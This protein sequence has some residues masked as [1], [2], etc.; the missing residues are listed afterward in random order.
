MLADIQRTVYPEEV[1]RQLH[2]ILEARERSPVIDRRSNRCVTPPTSFTFTANIVGPLYMR[3][4]L[5]QHFRWMFSKKNFV[6][7]YSTK[8]EFYSLFQPPFGDISVTYA[9][10]H[11]FLKSASSTSYSWQLNILR[12]KRYKRKSVEVGVFEGVGHSAQFQM[13]PDV[14]HLPLSVLEN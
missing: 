13:E 7:D 8:I 9:F 1:I 10:I 3:M 6:A 11:S 14:A 4:I 2:I 12:L 5:L